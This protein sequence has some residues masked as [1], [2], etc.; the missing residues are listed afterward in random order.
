MPRLPLVLCA[1]LLVTAG[2]GAV[3]AVEDPPGAAGSLTI[4]RELYAAAEYESALTMLDRLRAAHAKRDDLRSIE[5]YR[6][7]CLLALGRTADAEQ[8]IGAVVFA[9][10]GF[11]PADS[12]MSPRFRG[13]FREVRRRTLPTLAQKSY[14]DA[15][16]AFD[17]KDFADA[18]SGFSTVLQVLDDPDLAERSTQ[19]PLSDLRVVASAFR[20]LA[21]VA[22]APPEPLVPPP[23]ELPATVEPA[24]PPAP[25]IYTVE[26]RGVAAPVTVRQ[27]LPQPPGD[28]PAGAQGSVEVVI[29]EAGAVERAV[30][31]GSFG[32]RYD[33]LVLESARQWRYE[34]ATI[35]GRPV[36]FRKVVQI[37]VKREQPAV[38]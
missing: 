37:T 11:L 1:I 18:A 29:N 28:V 12:D 7:F 24:V 22:S 3:A 36:K 23:A 13:V 20:D 8:A 19:P 6:A 38:R 21:V 9:D 10:P 2:Q 15:K 27:G 35:D 4:A 30:L 33:R 34:P 16:A 26:D 14:A 5:Q 25:V 31:R 17:R 32:G